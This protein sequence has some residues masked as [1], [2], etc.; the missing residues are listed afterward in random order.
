MST[1]C[2][3]VGKFW[4]PAA[5]KGPEGTARLHVAITE[6]LIGFKYALPPDPKQAELKVKVFAKVLQKYPVW[7]VSAAAE[8][9]SGERKE[10]PTPADL[11]ELTEK[12]MGMWDIMARGEQPWEY[13]TYGQAYHKIMEAVK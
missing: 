10:A 4:M 9:W 5:D 12:E 1:L 2:E 8:T 13:L 3:R 11:A 6:A 7:A